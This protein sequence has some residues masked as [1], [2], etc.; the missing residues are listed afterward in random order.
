MNVVGIGVSGVAHPAALTRINRAAAGL[1]SHSDLIRISVFLSHPGSSHWRLKASTASWDAMT[2]KV[3]LIGFGEAGSTFALAG[4]WG[5]RAA[6]WDVRAERRALAATSGL[7]A[8]DGAAGALDGADL[9]LS[10]VTADAALDAAR[11]YAPHL[12]PG[13]LW[14]DMNSVALQT[15]QAAAAAIEAAG[16]RYVDVAV[17]APVQP[18]ALQ[19]P[20]LL[21]G[22]DAEDALDRLGALGFTGGVLAGEAIGRASAIKLCRSIMVKGT[23]ALCAEMALAAAQ[24]GVLDAVLA[25]L[26]ASER[27]RPWAERVD[28]NLDRMLAHGKRRAAEMFEATKMLRA[29][30]LSPLMSEGAVQWQEGLGELGVTSPDGLRAK[31]AAIAT[32]PEFKG[33]I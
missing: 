22:I 15:K 23:E 13:A 1:A 29:A 20:L 21:S 14:C 11:R 12:A 8:V 26:D 32:S 9:V 33:E 19:V 6:A 16:G 30:G 4:D 24:L 3:A 31:I 10:L 17:M 18:A 5:E 7:R 2:E 25:S 27:A 28:Y